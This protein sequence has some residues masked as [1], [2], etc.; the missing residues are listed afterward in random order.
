MKFR[1]I[2]GGKIPHYNNNPL[3][4]LNAP[5]V[6]I[7]FKGQYII[8]SSNPEKTFKLTDD[9][10]I[11]EMQPDTTMP[12]LISFSSLNLDSTDQFIEVNSDI[13]IPC[14]FYEYNFSKI[15]VFMNSI[16]CSL[17]EEESKTWYNAVVRKNFP[18]I[19]VP[20]KT[21][22]QYR[23][24]NLMS[25]PNLLNR[26]TF[27]YKFKELLAIFYDEK[28][29]KFD[30]KTAYVDD[31]QKQLLVDLEKDVMTMF[32]DDT[33]KFTPAN[34]SKFKN[35]NTWETLR[36]ESLNEDQ[37]I[38]NQLLMQRYVNFHDMISVLSTYTDDIK[39]HLEK[40]KYKEVYH[41]NATQAYQMYF[42][43]KYKVP[44]IEQNKDVKSYGTYLK[45]DINDI[46][47]YRKEIIEFLDSRFWFK[48]YTSNL[49]AVRPSIRLL[50]MYF[51]ARLNGSLTMGDRIGIIL[52][53]SIQTVCN[54]FN[55]K[56]FDT[57]PMNPTWNTYSMKYKNQVFQGCC[58][59]G[60]IEFIK[61]LCYD[62][63]SKAFN[64][65]LLPDN[66]RPE[67]KEFMDKYKPSDYGTE[68]NYNPELLAD[69]LNI[70][71]NRT[72][73]N[74]FYKQINVLDD[75]NNKINFELYAIKF[76][77]ILSFLLGETI[78][79]NTNTK[80][81]N[82]NP[83]ITDIK[84]YSQN[85]GET[86]IKIILTTKSTIELNVNHGHT[87]VA[88]FDYYSMHNVK[89]NEWFI[90]Y[91]NDNYGR[92]HE[93]SD[94]ELGYLIYNRV[95]ININRISI[96]ID[97]I[98]YIIR[99]INKYNKLGKLILLNILS[100]SYTIFYNMNSWI[101][102]NLSDKNF[103]ND[104]VNNTTKETTF[105]LLIIVYTD[106]GIELLLSLIKD[107]KNIPK[108]KMLVYEN[109][110][111]E[112]MQKEL[113]SYLSDP[114]YDSIRHLLNLEQPP[115]SGGSKRK[116]RIRYRNYKMKTMKK[117]KK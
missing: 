61:A 93:Y 94:S 81:I 87:S 104:I 6:D 112:P 58:E 98:K 18:F 5:N 2:K 91:C 109:D 108:N 95:L 46:F 14:D 56:T 37:K 82:K 20:E 74:R 99:N 34:V 63:N 17:P 28:Y 21:K 13:K 9:F 38:H 67:L 1:N 102:I 27:I 32:E 96:N 111:N 36:F 70:L 29:S 73:L 42:D 90:R 60:L 64:L 79:A 51:S 92:F 88:I 43:E 71:E 7:V 23:S 84:F 50:M 114:K 45:K 59:H 115:K 116:T 26:Y 106:F 62:S 66:T 80:L 25:K 110:N 49:S 86:N 97:E 15:D 19:I 22:N 107:G 3:F 89:V 39:G 52:P 12:N 69:L 57:T 40:D 100:D 31:S 33:I 101:G 55:L 72:E 78:N 68:P 24:I 53:I 105:D 8:K 65:K 47:H 117:C 35:A 77:D 54:V 48:N 44:F 16:L 76:F 83:F 85:N 30:M 75:A 4:L 113:Y 103:L 41:K 10:T 11:E